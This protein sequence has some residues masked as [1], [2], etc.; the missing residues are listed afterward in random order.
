MVSKGR[1]RKQTECE[2]HG[3]VLKRSWKDSFLQ[4]DSGVVLKLYQTLN[5][6]NGYALL[7]GGSAVL[8]ASGKKIE[9][10]TVPTGHV[11]Y[12]GL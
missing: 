7:Q 6:Q 10:P 1:V 11:Y 4:V 5:F 3:G 9:G 8:M 2:N 12:G